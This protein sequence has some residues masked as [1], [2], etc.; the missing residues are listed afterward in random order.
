MVR[1]SG[2]SPGRIC[3]SGTKRYW[4]YLRNTFVNP[5]EAPIGIRVESR[6][7]NVAAFGLMVGVEV[8]RHRTAVDRL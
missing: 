7:W 1:P 2:S 8:D 5:A 4:F 3:Q 6:V